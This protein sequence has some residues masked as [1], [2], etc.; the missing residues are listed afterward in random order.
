MSKWKKV[1]KHNSWMK[2]FKKYLLKVI[3]TINQ[4]EL[5]RDLFNTELEMNDLIIK[6]ASK[7]I[8]IYLI[9]KIKEIQ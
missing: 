1:I 3:K 8:I 9:F 2:V 7:P 5:V 4:K 6:E